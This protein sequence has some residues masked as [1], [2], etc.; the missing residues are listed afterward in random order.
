ML[1]E[2][3]AQACGVSLE[4]MVYCF[5]TPHHAIEIPSET[6]LYRSFEVIKC[7][8]VEAIDVFF[9]YTVLVIFGLYH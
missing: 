7:S 9:R 4:L 3:N 5:G 6:L 1:D 8:A 2:H